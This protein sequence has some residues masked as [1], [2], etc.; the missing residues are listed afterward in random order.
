M[1]LRLSL[2][3]ARCSDIGAV[4][5]LFSLQITGIVT[6]TAMADDTECE[7]LSTLPFL[8]LSLGLPRPFH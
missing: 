2:K 3:T 7:D 4:S 6:T 1:F 5:L 8:D